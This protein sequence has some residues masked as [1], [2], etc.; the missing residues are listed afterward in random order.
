MLKNHDSL[1]FPAFFNL[2]NTLNLY[3]SIPPC[4]RSIQFYSSFQVTVV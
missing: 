2:Y 3:V 1:K 4:P